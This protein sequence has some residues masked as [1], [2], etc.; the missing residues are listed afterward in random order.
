MEVLAL[1]GIIVIIILFLGVESY[2]LKYTWPI[3]RSKINSSWPVYDSKEGFASKTLGQWLPTPEVLTKPSVGECPGSLMNA[4]G[5]EGELKIKNYDLLNDIF[6][7]NIMNRVAKGPTSQK[8]YNVDYA[9][10]L[11]LSSYAQRTNNYKHKIPDS[12]SAPNHDL[13]LNFYN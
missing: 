8:C 12:C 6:P 3:A 13:I 4:A 2:Q 7:S 11:E 5:Y 9:P 1:L 10:T